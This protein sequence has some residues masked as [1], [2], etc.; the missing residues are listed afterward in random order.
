MN[1]TQ[2]ADMVPT[3]LPFPLVWVFAGSAGLIAA[4][5]AMLLGKYDKLAAALLALELLLFVLLLDFPA[6]TE[7]RQLAMFS[8][9]KDLSLCGGAMLY[10]AYIAKDRS[11]IG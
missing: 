3:Y 9:M 1:A 6:V 4:S 8:L 7:G 5:V 11:V 2:M 10:A